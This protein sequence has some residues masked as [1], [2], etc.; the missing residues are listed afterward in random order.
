MEKTMKKKFCLIGALLLSNLGFAKEYKIL[1]NKSY[2][3]VV[4]D[5]KYLGFHQAGHLSVAQDYKGSL[6]FDEKTQKGK[7]S[8]DVQIKKDLSGLA[9]GRE[10]H[11]NVLGPKIQN[12]S[13]VRRSPSVVSSSTEKKIQHYLSDDAYFQSEV[14]S[15]ISASGD[16]QKTSSNQ[17]FPFQSDM[18]VVLKG[19]EKTIPLKI[20][21]TVSDDNLHLEAMGAMDLMDFQ[22]KPISFL[23]KMGSIPSVVKLYF[24]VQAKK[25]VAH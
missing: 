2:L 8:F 17:T 14:F 22:F 23:G 6:S 9:F 21:L 7:F 5:K 20:R 3:S 16:I 11:V 19:I 15:S 25:Q 18:K 13:L 12:N 4:T 24:D 10:E 1:K